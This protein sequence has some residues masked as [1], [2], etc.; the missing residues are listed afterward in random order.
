MLK[1]AIAYGEE[2]KAKYREAMYDIANQYYFG[3]NGTRDLELCKNNFDRH[4]YVMVDKKDNIIG[5]VS[6]ALSYQTRCADSFGVISFDKGNPIIIQDMEQVLHDIFYVYNL[7][8]ISWR[9]FV[10]NPALKVYRD[11]IKKHGGYQSSYFVNA[12]ILM[13]G[14]FHDV[15]DFEIAKEDFI[16]KPKHD[17]TALHYDIQQEI[18]SCILRRLKEMKKYKY[19]SEDTDK[20]LEGYIRYIE[21][22]NDA[23]VV[24]LKEE[25]NSNR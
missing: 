19:I 4:E 16:E 2:L 21:Q 6:Y 22:G 1:P 14:K 23:I 17:E 8:R 20:I 9:C 18:N 5:Y 7:D 24:A 13:D 12:A 15:I 25:D 10:G 11:F 3:W